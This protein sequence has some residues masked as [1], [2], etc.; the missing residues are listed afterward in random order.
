M[1][2]TTVFLLASSLPVCYISSLISREIDKLYNFFREVLD[3]NE[4]V[5]QS[6]VEILTGS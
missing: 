5:S 1:D 3:M 4:K 2:V 6:F